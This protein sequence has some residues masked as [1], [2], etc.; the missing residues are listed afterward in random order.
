MTSATLLIGGVGYA[1]YL[2]YKNKNT[3]KKVKA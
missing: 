2:R 3:K 1:G